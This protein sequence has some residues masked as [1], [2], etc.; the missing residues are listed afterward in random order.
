MLLLNL[1]THYIFF[2]IS[3]HVSYF[4]LQLLQPPQ[5]KLLNKFPLSSGARCSSPEPVLGWFLCNMGLNKKKTSL[6]IS[7]FRCK[8]Y[9]GCL[10]PS[11]G[12]QLGLALRWA[13]CIQCC[14]ANYYGILMDLCVYQSSLPPNLKHPR[15]QRGH[16]RYFGGFKYWVQLSRGLLKGSRGIKAD[17]WCK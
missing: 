16:C 13:G 10:Q 15:E 2:R 11:P 6:F 1:T 7:S 5:H 3:I 14:V 9:H 8:W 4:R 12:Q 17:L